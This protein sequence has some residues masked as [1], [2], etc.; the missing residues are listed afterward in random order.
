LR[1]ADR[2]LGQSG[3]REIERRSMQPL[4]IYTLL[5]FE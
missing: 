5:V 2:V 4:G 3:M 1:A